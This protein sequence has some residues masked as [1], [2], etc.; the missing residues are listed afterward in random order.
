MQF[1]QL[2]TSQQPMCMHM[3]DYSHFLNSCGV[4]TA[5]FSL[6]RSD[7]TI[8]Q[9]RERGAGAQQGALLDVSHREKQMDHTLHS[10]SH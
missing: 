2:D 6:V 7:R 5:T 9:R 1:E 4:V 10:A 8:L 3:L